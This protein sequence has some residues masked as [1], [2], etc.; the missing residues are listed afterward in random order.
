MLSWLPPTPWPSWPLLCTIHGLSLLGATLSSMSCQCVCGGVGGVGCVGRLSLTWQ[1]RPQTVG[2][3]QH[4]LEQFAGD[5]YAYLPLVAAVP[6]VAG[7][8]L[9]CLQGQGRSK[10]YK[11][12]A[13]VVAITLA[14]GVTTSRQLDTWRSDDSMWKHAIRLVGAR[15]W[16]GCGGVDSSLVLHL[17]EW[18]QQTGEPMH[19][20]QST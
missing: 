1:T 8:I 10:A 13:V 20:M 6:V 15:G 18:T 14:F 12:V 19:C 4:G 16:G 7:I 17:T 3:V 5:R 11:V 9:W 2:L